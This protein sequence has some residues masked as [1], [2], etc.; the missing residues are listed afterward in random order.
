MEKEEACL[1]SE[2]LNR[3]ALRRLGLIIVMNGSNTD[4]MPNNLF[5]LV[6][7]SPKP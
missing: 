4:S 7:T 2:D 1:S 6:S 3:I 5:D